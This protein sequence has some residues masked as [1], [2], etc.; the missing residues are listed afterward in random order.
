MCVTNSNFKS[1]GLNKTHLCAIRK[2]F[3][4]ELL[5]ASVDV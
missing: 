3:L 1:C 2:E 4:D 5:I